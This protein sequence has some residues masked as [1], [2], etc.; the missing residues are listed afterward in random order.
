VIL[1]SRNSGMLHN[2]WNWVVRFGRPSSLRRAATSSGIFALGSG[3]RS[4]RTLPARARSSGSETLS[5]IRFLTG[6]TIDTHESSFQ[7]R[8]P[9]FPLWERVGTACAVQPGQ[10]DKTVRAHAFAHPT[11]ETALPPHRIAGPCM[12]SGSYPILSGSQTMKLSRFGIFTC[13]RL[14]ASITSFSPMILL[15]QRT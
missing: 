3:F 13:G 11:I 9:W 5:Q 12:R 15:S 2:A 10:A 8:Q 6:Y 14:F 1:N 7:K 4:G